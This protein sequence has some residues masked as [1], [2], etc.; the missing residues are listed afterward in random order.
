MLC[1]NCKRN[2]AGV[3]LKRIINGEA[4]EIHLCG[5]CAVALGIGDTAGSFSPFGGVQGGNLSH[6]DTR[7]MS[8]K[9]IRCETC[10]FSFEDIARTGM[11]GCP[12]CYRVFAGKLRPT[13][14]KLH[15]RA[16]F[17]GKGPS[18]ADGQEASPD[19]L[20][21]LRE[22]LEQAVRE[23]NFEL[24]AVLRDEIRSLSEKEVQ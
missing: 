10:G 11:P 22:R 19:S 18:F 23:E 16:V 9:G 13:L 2:D 3:H 6:A 20:S 5:T 14:V 24:A 17:N 1:Q 15:G 12:D 21:E 4:A 8:N 7:R